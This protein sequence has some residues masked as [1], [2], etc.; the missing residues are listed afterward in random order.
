VSSLPLVSICTQIRN[1][2]AWAKEMI[3]SVVASTYKNW[4]LIVVDDGSTEDLK[5]VLASFQD[6]RIKYIR[7]DES[8]GVPKGSNEAVRH[9]LGKYVCLIAADEVITPEK[10][11]EQVEYLEANPNVDCVWG[12]PN[13]GV[14][15]ANQA[16]GRRP[17][18]EQHAL[19]ASNRSRESWLRTLL[20][21]D[22]VPLGSCSMMM[23][24]A[25]MDVLEG[26]NESLTI[27]ADHEMYVRFFEA[28]YVG[29][30]L[31]Y[32]W[33][34]DKPA[35]PE[36]VRAVNAHKG[37]DEYKWVCEH[38]PLVPPPADGK[39]T[40]A[41]PCYN[42]ARFLKAALDSVRKQTRPVDEI[43]IL[44]DASTDNFDEVMRDLQ[45]SYDPRLKIMAFDENRG[46]PEALNQ[47][48]Y[49]AEGE[50]F[51]PL[52]AD[53][54]LAPNFVQACL[55]EFKQH[56]W[57]ELVATHTD[58]ITEAGKPHVEDHPFKR[59]PK[60]QNHATREEFLAYLHPGNRYFGAGMYRTKAI[61]EVG[62]WEKKYKV[63]SD[64]QM[65]I[66]LLQRENIRVIEQPL[67]HTRIH[68][69]N[70]SLLDTK[71]AKELPWLY[72]EAR[73]PYFR[74]HMKVIIATPFYEVKAFSPYITSLA[75]TIRLL[76]SVGIDWHFF[77]L[78]GDSY[79][80]RAR[81]TMCDLFLRDP[82]ATDLFFIDSDMSWNPEAFVRMC[83]LPDEIVG[84]TYPVK[85][86][87]DRWTSVPNVYTKGDG[88]EQIQEMRGRRLPDGSAL[89]EAQ[90]LAGGF[91]RIKR[92][93]LEKFRDKYPDD[94]YVEPSTD[95]SEPEHKYTRFFGAESIDHKF[96]GE[97]HYFSKRLRD[98][99][100][101]M[102]IYPN[103][104]MV[105]WGYKDFRGNYDKWLKQQV[106]GQGK[107][108]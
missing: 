6:D 57:S 67:T 25:V 60:A 18:W 38:H 62:G 73:K 101:P 96:Y 20:T 32:R 88:K 50:F 33:A 97:D 8:R 90:V 81:N 71:R 41:I 37:Q 64:Y 80:H 55:D 108:A 35:G 56:P 3:A 51:V 36:S 76:T 22:N 105:H 30:V 102:M 61:S 94:W 1:Q 65:Y 17:D 45:P 5:G 83:M 54:T 89:I 2:T 68:G 31:P 91:L 15:G 84:G 59:I 75:H 63:I 82:D 4:E 24:K 86:A 99:G 95:P 23:H 43:L 49:R 69:K 107:A 42:H 93:V 98:I 44:N 100:I 48:A 92:S 58:F 52:S 10:L 34:T 7:W 106:A 12:L 9:A 87:W 85:N 28:G 46:M 14:E 70:D 74:K 29:V 19:K 78:S 53:D 13:A 11:A 26:Q 47:M 27:F 104:D 72:H 77:E 40:V 16:I 39:V 103:V 21:L 79:V 66:K